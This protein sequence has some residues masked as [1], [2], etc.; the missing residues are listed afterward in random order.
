MIVVL[1]LMEGLHEGAEED[2]GT[3]D[4]FPFTVYTRF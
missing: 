3:C 4:V 1:F 2:Q